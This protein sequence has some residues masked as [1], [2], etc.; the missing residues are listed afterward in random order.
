MVYQ[1]WPSDLPQEAPEPHWQ[2]AAD[3]PDI[4][5]A[6]IFAARLGDLFRPASDDNDVEE[7]Q[8]SD[9]EWRLYRISHLEKDTLVQR[10]DEYWGTW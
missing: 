9:E 7:A 10:A 2:P 4:L 3:L 1:I 8:V 6:P 5:C